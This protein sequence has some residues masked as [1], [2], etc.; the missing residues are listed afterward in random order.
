MAAHNEGKD[1]TGFF[2]NP[3]PTP[4]PGL[5]QFRIDSG[6]TNLIDEQVEHFGQ[7][8]AHPRPSPREETTVTNHKH[9]HMNA[10]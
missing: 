8:L 10:L 2:F 4:P 9:C 7:R 1:T 6:S 5:F 3:P